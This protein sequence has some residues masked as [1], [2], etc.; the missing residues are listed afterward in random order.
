MNEI[1]LRA[2]MAA[3]AV[4]QMFSG[5][6]GQLNRNTFLGD[7]IY[8]LAGIEAFT[9]F[10]EIG[11]WNGQGSTKCFMDALLFRRDDS[12]IYSLESNHDFH[13]QAQRY[14]RSVLATPMGKEKLKLIY[15]RII[16][17]SELLTCDQ[18]PE[19]I[20]T[21]L[22]HYL[23]WRDNDTFDYGQSPNVIDL[24]P[25]QIDVLLLD[26]GEFSTY[27]EFQKLRRRTGVILLDDTKLL[28]CKKVREELLED[29]AWQVIYDLP[30]ER[31]G[32]FIACRED[33]D[34]HLKKLK[35]F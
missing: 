13:E 20:S 14:W 19:E 1:K 30:D 29:K 25:R 22:P 10:V 32:S 8:R 15:G 11:T 23:R 16:E 27:A 24:L 2:I 7:K 12:N 35:K 5:G 17:I 28:K 4:L 9:N 26:G 6:G 31:N 34:E 33:Y 18:I 3:K 21:E